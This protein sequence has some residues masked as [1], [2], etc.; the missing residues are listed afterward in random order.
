MKS[1]KSLP[2]Y[3]KRKREIKKRKNAFLILKS[4]PIRENSL[5]KEAE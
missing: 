3:K 2:W 5:R 1:K 4:L